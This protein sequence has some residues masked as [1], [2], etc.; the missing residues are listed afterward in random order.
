[1]IFGGYGGGDREDR[2]SALGMLLMVILA[3]IAAL[4][5]QLG[6]SRQ[7][8]YAADAAGARL[9]GQPYGLISALKKLGAYNQRIPM[10][11][12]PSTSSLFIVKP[13]SAGSVVSGLFSTHPPLVDRIA[14]LERMT[15]S[16]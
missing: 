12:P 8:E 5:L 9:V 2:G 7:R 10:H 14:E 1:M 11:V 3:P 4:L 6:L 16:R 13:L 15:M